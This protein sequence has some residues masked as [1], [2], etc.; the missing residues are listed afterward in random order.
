MTCLCKGGPDCCRNAKANHP[1]DVGVIKYS[2]PVADRE[3][4]IR[5][6]V[7]EELDKRG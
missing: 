4:Q 2:D 3:E 1:L 7:R 5:R 6:I